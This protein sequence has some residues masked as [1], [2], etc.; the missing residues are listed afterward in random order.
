[1]PNKEWKCHSD[2]ITQILVLK[3]QKPEETK[4]RSGDLDEAAAS[5]QK[6]KEKAKSYEDYK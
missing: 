3:P 6:E 4:G 5:L 2:N 1:M